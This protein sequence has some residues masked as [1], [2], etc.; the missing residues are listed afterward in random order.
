MR[1]DFETLFN[2]PGTFYDCD[3]NGEFAPISDEKLMENVEKAVPVFCFNGEEEF[4]VTTRICHETSVQT[5]VK[6]LFSWAFT[7]KKKGARALVVKTFQT[8][9]DFICHLETTGKLYEEPNFMFYFETEKGNI[10]LMFVT[11]SELKSRRSQKK[12]RRLTQSHGKMDRLKWAR[13]VI[14]EAEKTAPNEVTVSSKML[15]T[16]ELQEFVEVCHGGGAQ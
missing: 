15:D 8:M 10:S 5:M 4:P 12:I 9:A 13:A 11:F 2:N 7:Q 14:L 6:E 16:E 3:E 1:P